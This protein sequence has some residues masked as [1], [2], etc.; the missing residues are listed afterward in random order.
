MIEGKRK[1]QAPKP[2]LLLGIQSGR[3]TPPEEADRKGT[4]PLA[5]RGWLH[6]FIE[7]QNRPGPGR[8]PGVSKPRPGAR[9]NR[10]ST[11]VRESGKKRRRESTQIGQSGGVGRAG[12][13]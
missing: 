6:L 11:Q 2:I 1:E 10:G 7:L 5:S 4:W 3:H 13:A 12:G 9:K 8:T